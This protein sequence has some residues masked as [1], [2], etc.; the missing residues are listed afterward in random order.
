[1]WLNNNLLKY[2][3]DLLLSLSI[4]NYYNNNNKFFVRK[5]IYGWEKVA[6]DMVDDL[7]KLVV[8]FMDMKPFSRHTYI[9][10]A[11]LFLFWRVLSHIISTFLSVYPLYSLCSSSS[12]QY[13]WL[14]F[15]FFFEYK[16][17]KLLFSLN[18]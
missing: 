18:S 16:S 15:D 6:R 17:R 12:H 7:H 10:M 14:P 2:S 11:R 9:A 4:I 13:L 3:T 8:A 1:M 5:L